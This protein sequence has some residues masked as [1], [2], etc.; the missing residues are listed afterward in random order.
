MLPRR[1]G[2]ASRAV[3]CWPL[4]ISLGLAGGCGSVEPPVDE[5]AAREAPSAEHPPSDPS[6]VV[7]SPRAS[8][9][10]Q[11]ESSR[12]AGS[13]ESALWEPPPAE[14]DPV[15]RPEA[16]GTPASSNAARPSWAPRVA[17]APQVANKP[18]L[19]E[20]AT[21]TTAEQVLLICRVEASISGVD[22]YSRAE[23][24]L[25]LRLPGR[26]RPEVSNRDRGRGELVSAPVVSLTKG[27]RLEASL[28]EK[29]LFSDDPLGR[30]S[31][32]Y[33]GSLPLTF[34]GRLM[35]VE[36]RGVPREVVE[37]E[38]EP[39]LRRIDERLARMITNDP[40]RLDTVD[41]GMGPEGPSG[42]A[43]VQAGLEDAAALVG[44]DDPRVQARRAR[45]EEVEAAFTRGIATQVERA[46][47]VV[48][49]GP[50]WEL[51]RGALRI[52]GLRLACGR[53]L[54]RAHRGLSL[55]YDC[56]LLGEVTDA[57]TTT[58][59]VLEGA[60]GGLGPLQRLRVADLEG[61]RA[62]LAAVAILDASVPRAVAP[63]TVLPA[64]ETRRIT[65]ALEALAQGPT[66]RPPL[67]LIAE[68]TA[69]G[70]DEPE[71]ERV[72]VP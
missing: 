67:L 49:E 48:V 17:Y 14:L 13:P 30:V 31:G 18:A 36:C 10:S 5:R 6:G 40:P 15:P 65:L 37:R 21:A 1:S 50:P 28:A 45:L 52:E 33:G 12:P 25:R 69:D 7:E 43:N 4:V 46:K 59:A 19:L 56:A 58:V 68:T 66:P 23:P 9:S 16:L 53:E 60:S 2:S 29:D 61:R 72:W 8:E 24:Y 55:A 71:L 44:W 38:L 51:G 62:R 27:E 26:G 22:S 20:L 3:V 70:S 35:T 54:A 63:D 57:S 32:T 34:G 11:P 64:G 42:T 47:A 39:A 41:F